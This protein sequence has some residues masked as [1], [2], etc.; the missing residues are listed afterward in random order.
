MMKKI[1]ILVTG[2]FLIG[3]ASPVSAQLQ[4]GSVMM[5]GDIAGLKL[6]LNSGSNIDFTLNPKA[7]WFIKDGLAVGAYMMFGINHV[8]KVG[9]GISYGIG[10]L[11]RYYISDPNIELTRKARFFLEAHVGIEGTNPASGSTTNGLGFGVGPGLAYFITPNIALETLVKY[12]G[13]AGFGSE[14][15]TGDISLNIGFQIYFSSQKVKSM[16]R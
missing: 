5:G 16:R 15:Y 6:G 1:I 12:N 8:D 7:A 4:K 10:P 11:G 14:A 3:V 13:R 9:T 2:V